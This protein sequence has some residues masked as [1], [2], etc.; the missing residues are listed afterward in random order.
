[1]FKQLRFILWLPPFLR[2]LQYKYCLFCFVYLLQTKRYVAYFLQSKRKK[3]IYP[4]F[5]PQYLKLLPPKNSRNKEVGGISLSCTGTKYLMNFNSR[6]ASQY[7][8]QLRGTPVK[9]GSA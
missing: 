5:P 4:N 9:I 1:M 6:Y 3:L 8:G 7:S 2:K